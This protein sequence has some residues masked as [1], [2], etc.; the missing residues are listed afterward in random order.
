[1]CHKACLDFIGDKFCQKDFKGLDVLEV[2]SYDVNGSVRKLID[3]YQ[4]KSYKGVDIFK[5]PGVDQICPV[6]KLVSTFGTRSFD[7]VLSTEMLEHVED[8]R[9]A[10]TNLK[11]VLKPNGLLILTTRSIGFPY[12]GYPYDFWRY[13]IDDFKQIFSDMDVQ[14]LIADADAPGVFL[15][16]RKMASSKPFSLE[17][18]SLYSIR[19]GKR[20]FSAPPLSLR[21]RSLLLFKSITR[22]FLQ[23]LLPLSIQGK[24][25]NFFLRT[26]LK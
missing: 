3:R 8:W 24:L 25:N 15:K 18:V 6:G 19:S 16:A 14:S 4:P 7:V 20:A 11:G 9:E 23:H 26:F 17:G 12:H 13:E 5:G 1:M 21:I 22:S 10:I 2:G